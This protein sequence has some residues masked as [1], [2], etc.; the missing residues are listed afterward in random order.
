M[1]WNNNNK[2][3]QHQYLTNQ[4]GEVLLFTYDESTGLVSADNAGSLRYYSAGQLTVKKTLDENTNDIIEYSDKQGRTL[5]R[6]VYS[7]TNAGERQYA[8]TYYI[9]DDIGNL[10]VVLPP[11]GVNAIVSQN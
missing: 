3:V 6:K 9:Y 1:S 10:V 8:C 5:C 4:S 11:E 7:N 2:F